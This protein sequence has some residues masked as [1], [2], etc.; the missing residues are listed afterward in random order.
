M[1]IEKNL[2]FKKYQIIMRHN[3]APKVFIVHFTI[4]K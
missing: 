4:V 2:D 3:V 1:N